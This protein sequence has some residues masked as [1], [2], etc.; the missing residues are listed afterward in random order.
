MIHA[1][2]A[3]N[4]LKIEFP[5]EQEGIN[6]I[7]VGFMQASANNVLHKC[8]GVKDGLLQQI[9]CPSV[10]DCNGNQDGYF[11][12]HY[13][14]Y[15]VNCQGMCDSWL[16]FTF[17]AIAAPGKVPDQVAIERT[18]F[19]RYYKTFQNFTTSSATQHILCLTKYLSLSQEV[20]EKYLRRILSISILANCESE[21]KWHLV[22]L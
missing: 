9:N 8:L 22:V 16:R 15:G 20:K 7:R 4:E 19:L 11:S 10:D 6:N 13:Q 17:F 2:L 5:T 21:L 14:T 12:G 18:K 3:C 1:I